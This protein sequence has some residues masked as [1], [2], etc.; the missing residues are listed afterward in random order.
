MYGKDS[1]DENRP[2]LTLDEKSGQK[3]AD[4]DNES[5][6][7][8]PQAAPAGHRYIARWPSLTLKKGPGPGEADSADAA[9]APLAVAAV[10][11]KA[12]TVDQAAAFVAG[13][14]SELHM[15]GLDEERVR[16]ASPG[17]EELKERL[18]VR[19]S[20]IRN[21]IDRDQNFRNFEKSTA[22]FQER[23]DGLKAVIEREDDPAG[24]LVARDRQVMRHRQ[25]EAIWPV[26]DTYCSDGVLEPF[27]YERLVD[28]AGRY[29]LE[30]ED[31]DELIRQYDDEL[32]KTKGKRLERVSRDLTRAAVEW[33]PLFGF[34]DLADPVTSLEDLHENAVRFPG[35]ARKLLDD[36]EISKWLKQVEFILK[37]QGTGEA[38]L[39]RV[40]A[41]GR[42]AVSAEARRGSDDALWRFLWKTGYKKLHFQGRGVSRIVEIVDLCQGKAEKLVSLISTDMLADWCEIVHKDTSLADAARTAGVKGA[43]VAA[44]D[45]LW[46]AGED[47][48]TLEGNGPF[49][50]PAEVARFARELA[51]NID[52]IKRCLAD[53]TLAAWT[54]AQEKRGRIEPGYREAIE[55]VEREAAAAGATIG[56]FDA[57]KA[58]YMWGLDHLPLFSGEGAPAGYVT[59]LEDIRRLRAQSPL[60]LSGAVASGAFAA[61]V[62]IHLE[63]PEA[64]EWQ[65]WIF[66][67]LRACWPDAMC[68][69]LGD[70]SLLVE[71]MELQSF[72]DVARLFE[73]GS[74]LP[75]RAFRS[76]ALAAWL[77]EIKGVEV[78]EGAMAESKRHRPPDDLLTFL[79][80]LGYRKPGVSKPMLEVWTSAPVAS[81]IPIPAE[82]RLSSMSCSF[83]RPAYQEAAFSN[84]DQNEAFLLS[85]FL[86]WLGIDRFYLGYYAL[87]AIK[88]ITLGGFGIWSFIDL[89][90]IGGGSLKDSNGRFLRRQV[91]GTPQKSQMITFLLS[92]LLPLCSC[93]LVSGMD[94]F[95]LGQYGLGVLKFITFGGCGVWTIVD[96]FLI[97]TGTLRD[98]KGNS[99]R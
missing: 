44:R 34:G 68:W 76:G 57:F 84:K 82:S 96:I 29:N 19:S 99:L 43:G 65:S 74:D 62:A 25:K 10:K 2:S 21:Q 55:R 26:I 50:N 93:F 16:A 89:I 95:Y 17:R 52:I 71:G 61:W 42:E 1:Q 73:Q 69:L 22:G 77:E 3:K 90:L 72:E 78:V 80:T 56:V 11:L 59:S 66:T 88:L 49:T 60:L 46:L 9:A 75:E 97:G 12:L 92:Y 83:Q 54:V 30:K 5:S 81:G 20:M 37:R 94:R 6:A 87:G 36:R 58:A 70:R 85:F 67:R 33:P 91:I 39:E 48:L 40:W 13:T 51:G 24:W 31:I 8:L 45:W 23:L 53:G 28:D 35:K 27:E 18:R 63:Y 47:R 98:S 38:E 4:G 79:W 64:R 15:L 14:F 32:F 41:T 86:G 7:A